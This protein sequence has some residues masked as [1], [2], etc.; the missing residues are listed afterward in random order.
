MVSDDQILEAY[1]WLAAREGIFC[2]PASAAT[3]AGLVKLRQQGLNLAGKRVVC[4]ITG[5]GLKDPEVAV[6]TAATHT[7]EVESNIEALEA[8]MLA[9]A[10]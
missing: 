1:R 9:V 2:E 6:S 8:V 3:L 5:S 4:I 7:I 10:L